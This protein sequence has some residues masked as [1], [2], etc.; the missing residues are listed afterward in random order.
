MA[1]GAAL[2]VAVLFLSSSSSL[3]RVVRISIVSLRSFLSAASLFSSIR[4]ASR[5]TFRF[6]FS[7]SSG[8]RAREAFP[9]LFGLLL[10]LSV[11]DGSE[12]ETDG[13]PEE[14]TAF[15]VVTKDVH[16][17]AVAM[18]V[19]V[20]DVL[21]EVAG[22]KRAAFELNLIS[23]AFRGIG[24]DGLDTRNSVGNGKGGGGGGGG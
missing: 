17:V 10:E 2:L 7:N 21:D 6:S 12:V 18:N 11:V 9:F 1:A 8:V 15:T 19:F 13:F 23:T 24:T 4:Q 14:E 3:H 22:T 16:G 5:S 20:E